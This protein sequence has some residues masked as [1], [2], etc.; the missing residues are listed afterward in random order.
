MARDSGSLAFPAPA[1][2]QVPVPRDIALSVP[3]GTPSVP[4]RVRSLI[5]CRFGRLLVRYYA[6]ADRHG[7]SY[8]CCLCD[9]G[10]VCRVPG[11]RLLGNTG[12]EGNHSQKSCGCERAD[13]SIRKA[14]RLTMPPA[15]RK[16]ICL[17]MRRSIRQR[18]PPYSMD[19]H[20]AAELLGVSVERIEILAQDGMLGSTIR[21]GALWVSSQDVSAM[22]ATQQRNKRRCRIMDALMGL[23][24]SGPGSSDPTIS[25]PALSPPAAE[26]A[27]GPGG[28]PRS[29]ATIG[30]V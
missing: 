30:S 8:W 15:R 11:S 29:A 24:G 23:S 9:C 6:G 3:R 26:R 20:R 21:R 7:R 22:I 17:K 16:E 10:V 28:R 25:R 5:G 4:P 12:R 2:A 18:K 19:A 14:A 1:R 27:G 13:P